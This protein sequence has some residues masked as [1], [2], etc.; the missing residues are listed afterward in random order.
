MQQINK[1]F[2]EKAEKKGIRYIRNHGSRE[3]TK[4]MN[5]QDIYGTSSCQVNNFY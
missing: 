1:T 5:W 4:Y 3:V 2:L